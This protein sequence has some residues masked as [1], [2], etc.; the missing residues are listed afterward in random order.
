MSNGNLV[1]YLLSN[2]EISS[3]QVLSWAKDIAA[4]MSHLHLEGIVHRDLAVRNLLLTSTLE[5]KISDFGL[6]RAIQKG[7]DG[8]NMSQKTESHVGP[9]KW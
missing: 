2:G 9:L 7:E 3:S 1:N 6:A 5:I 8:T 4:G